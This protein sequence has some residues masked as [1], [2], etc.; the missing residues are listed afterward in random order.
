MIVK[1]IVTKNTIKLYEQELEQQKENLNAIKKDFI[2]KE[3][4]K[5]Y[6]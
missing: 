5:N 3:I 1:I 4:S 6:N 2:K